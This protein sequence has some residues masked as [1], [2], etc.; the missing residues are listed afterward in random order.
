MRRIL[1]SIPWIRPRRALLQ[2]IDFQRLT[3]CADAAA[4]GTA[5]AP[6]AGPRAPM[7]RIF[8]KNAV[9]VSV[10]LV[11]ASLG[12]YNIVLKA[13]WTIMDDGVFWKDEAQ[14]VV[15]ARV[16][17]GV[18]GA[19]AGIHEGDV[20]LALGGEEVVNA[21][22]V[23]AHLHASHQGPLTY[24]LLRADDAAVARGARAAALPGAGQPVL[25]PVPRRLLQPA[26]RHHRD[27]APAARP[28]RA[29]LLRHLPAVLPDVLA[30]VHRQAE[31][32]R[33]DALLGAT[34]WRSCC[35]RSSSCT[36][37]CRSPSAA[38]PPRAAG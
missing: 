12:I 11:L 10:A 3:L 30:V 5:F 14:G 6:P 17:A 36:S 25:L 28:R 34:T 33:L 32:R 35:C 9:V 27:A 23:E 15:A 7:K 21:V 16:A 19:L 18:P 37:A 8:L 20:L 13:T 31:P 1:D 4:E 38:C 2:S 24:S 22:Q 26:G 29:A